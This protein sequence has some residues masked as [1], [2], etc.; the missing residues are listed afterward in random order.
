MRLRNPPVWA[1]TNTST[2]HLNSSS[3]KRWQPPRWNTPATKRWTHCGIWYKQTLIIRKENTLHRISVQGISFGNSKH[4]FSKYLSDKDYKINRGTFAPNL[5]FKNNFSIV[6]TKQENY[7]KCCSISDFWLQTIC[8]YICR[9][10]KQPLL[11]PETVST[12]LV[13]RNL[14]YSTARQA[15]KNTCGN[16]HKNVHQNMT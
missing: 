9:Q 11:Q 6:C 2:T 15:R 1:K 13:Q 16:S 3:T 8:R 5:Y 14:I 4:S 12:S 7:K 10:L